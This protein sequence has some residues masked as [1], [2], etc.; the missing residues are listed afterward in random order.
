MKHLDC[1]AR[2]EQMC[3]TCISIGTCTSERSP[4]LQRITSQGRCVKRS[5]EPVTNGMWMS[6]HWCKTVEAHAVHAWESSRCIRAHL[7][8]RQVADLEMDVGG[9]LLQ[10][11]A[12]EAVELLPIHYFGT[13]RGYPAD[14]PCGP[15]MVIGGSRV[16]LTRNLR[17]DGTDRGE[18]AR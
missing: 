18:R 15:R 10:A 8:A 9:T 11:Q 17:T 4:R 3:Y 16:A 12:Q 13:L 1:F 7:R 14:S 2:D 5:P 6:L